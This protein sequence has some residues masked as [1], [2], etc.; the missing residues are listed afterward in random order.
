MPPPVIETER[1]RLR[2]PSMDDLADHHANLGGDAEVAWLGEAGTLPES[3]KKLR[4]RIE[5]FERHGFGLW[6]VEDKAGGEFLGEAGIQYLEGSAEE[7]EVGYYLARSAWGR[8]VATEAGRAALAHGFQTLGL[9]HVVAVV[10]PENEGSKRV[11]AKLGLAFDHH[12]GHYGVE[13]VEVWRIDRQRH[14]PGA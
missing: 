11:L 7:V 3:E 6:I 8:G 2:P 13:R 4:H 14:M 9:D 10:R 1:L 5:H 12:A